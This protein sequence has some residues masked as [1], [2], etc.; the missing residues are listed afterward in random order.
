MKVHLVIAEPCKAD[1]NAMT[2][3]TEG[4]FC[5]LCQKNVIDF[6]DWST[7]DIAQYLATH[8]SER[9][10]GRVRKTHLQETAT[11]TETLTPILNWHTSNKRR[12]AALVFV[13]LGLAIISCNNTSSTKVQPSNYRSIDT[14]KTDTTVNTSVD[15]DILGGLG[16]AP[17]CDSNSLENIHVPIIPDGRQY[18]DL[19]ETGEIIYVETSDTA[20]TD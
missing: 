20:T 16:I 5:S 3:N 13:S 10:C 6:T 11:I 17:Q 14:P 4:K 8:S 1:W 12:I 19:I 9:T 18:S 7:N 15:E 2:P